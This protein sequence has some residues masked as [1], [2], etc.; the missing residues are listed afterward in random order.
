[1]ETIQLSGNIP[2]IILDGEYLLPS[3]L[4]AI[5]QNEKL[6]FDQQVTLAKLLVHQLPL[7]QKGY[8]E[9][10]IHGLDF[11]YIAE[12]SLNRP[13]VFT[14]LVILRSEYRKLLHELNESGLV[15]D[16]DYTLSGFLDTRIRELDDAILLIS[17]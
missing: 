4:E 14:L 10:T 13:R 1:M 15:E 7:K 9:L 2:V 3:L 12:K 5:N 17:F 11:Q 8:M 16:M 6:T